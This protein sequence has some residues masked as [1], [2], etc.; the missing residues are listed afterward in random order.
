M[1]MISI[2]ATKHTS[3]VTRQVGHAKK[4]TTCPDMCAVESAA[5]LLTIASCAFCK[6]SCVLIYKERPS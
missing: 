6:H 5:R 4:P 1:P 3:A 2:D